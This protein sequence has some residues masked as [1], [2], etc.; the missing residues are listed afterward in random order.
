MMRNM[1]HLKNIEVIALELAIPIVNESKKISIQH[2]LIVGPLNNQK[3]IK[4]I[5]RLR[6]LLKNQNQAYVIFWAIIE[7]TWIRKNT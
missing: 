5:N 6:L 4:L 3:K 2:L 1:F 7:N